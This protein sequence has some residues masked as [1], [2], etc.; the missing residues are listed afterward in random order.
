MSD[1]PSQERK[2]PAEKSDITK[3][4]SK[5]QTPPM[6]SIPETQPQCKNP[7]KENTDHEN[8]NRLQRFHLKVQIG[9]LIATTLAF[10]AAAIYAEIAYKQWCTMNATFKEIEKQTAASKTSAEA[11]VNAVQVAKDTLKTNI[12]MARQDQR[13]WIGATEIIAPKLRAANNK[14]IYIKEESPIQFAAWIL[15]SGKSP[16]L[17]V[18]HSVNFIIIPTGK[19]FVADYG[20]INKQ[21]GS[22]TVLQP[23]MGL[24]IET[25]PSA[26]IPATVVDAIKN[27]QV[28][29]YFFGKITYS[30]IFKV[31]HTTTFCMY[32][33]PSLDAFASSYAYN[34]A[35]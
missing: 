28:I 7:Q 12:E 30:D 15:N 10:I 13:A 33:S 34:D 8:G 18:K 23:Q 16:A 29:L 20:P 31:P 19:S 1:K 5:P 22:L 3:Q 26:P 14:P 11:A 27:G 2:T 21:K 9:L 24:K 32:L 35:N 6:P 4:E 17:E 25:V